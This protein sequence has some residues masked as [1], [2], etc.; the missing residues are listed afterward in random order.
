MADEWRHQRDPRQLPSLVEFV[1]MIAIPRVGQTVVERQFLQSATRYFLG[2]MAL[3]GVMVAIG[4]TALLQMSQNRR[5][6]LGLS[7][8]EFVNSPADSASTAMRSLDASV[9]NYPE[10]AYFSKADATK[11]RVALARN[12]FFGTTPESTRVVTDALESLG[13]D[14]YRFVLS[15][16]ERYPQFSY[17]SLKMRLAELPPGLAR[18]RVA[19]ALLYLRQPEPVR[20][21]ILLN[22]KDPTDATALLHALTVI[23][24]DST[25]TLALAQSSMKEHDPDTLFLVLLAAAETDFSEW[26]DTERSAWKKIIDQNYRGDPD[27]GVHAACRYLAQQWGLPSPP[28]EPTDYPRKGFGW[29]CVKLAPGVTMTFV[30]VRPGTYNRGINSPVNERLQNL[31]P[32][33]MVEMPNEY[34]ISQTEATCGLLQAWV[35]SGGRGTSNLA[36]QLRNN[37]RFVSCLSRANI[38]KPMFCLSFNE[39]K[40]LTEWLNS[41]ACFPGFRFAIP[42][43]DEWEF[44]VR[45]GSETFF[46]VGDRSVSRWMSR[47]AVIKH[48]YGWIADHCKFVENV[49]TRIPDRSGLFDTAG[50]LAEYAAPG[51]RELAIDAKPRV[52]L[53][54][55]MLTAEGQFPPGSYA[56]RGVNDNYRFQGTR[57][58]IK[59]DDQVRKSSY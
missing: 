19:A 49:A 45:N 37:E 31:F 7:Y 40:S 23:W 18:T 12:H 8:I 51:A 15:E 27:P 47:H 17:E 32:C 6:R 10:F 9:L 22:R 2:R 50:S 36:Q 41:S 29:W 33:Q 56:S 1:P 13:N 53:K 38:Q 28:T 24:P 25:K 14:E 55:G 46:V 3:V 35:A 26:D 11:H 59:F 54:G 48:E 57:F 4:I 16:L 39:T 21:S 20:E 5:D 30:R 34:W 42:S 44:A 52:F 43:P 58:V